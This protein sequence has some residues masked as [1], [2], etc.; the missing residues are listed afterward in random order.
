[1][2]FIS[3]NTF[4]TIL[5]VI[6]G[7]AAIALLGALTHQAASVLLPVRAPA[8]HFVARFRAVQGAG[9][10]TAVCV[11]WV[12]T[13]IM[14]AW[15]YTKYRVYVRIPLEELG[16]WKTVGFFD[17]KEHMVTIGLGMLPVYWFFWK[18]ARA[19]EYDSARKWL[20]VVLAMIC[21]FVFLVGHVLNNARGFGT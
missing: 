11:L 19:T 21:W 8:K 3:V 10:A 15:I 20:T 9:Y 2:T 14:G 7:L 5:L 12:F 4:W 16:Y 13:F 17:F 1:M 18:H 6:H